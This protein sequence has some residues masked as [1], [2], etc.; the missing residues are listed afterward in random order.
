[1]SV[2]GV[3]VV[4]W[5][6]GAMLLCFTSSNQCITSNVSIATRS[7]QTSPPP[8]PSVCGGRGRRHVAA[9]RHAPV[10]PT[11]IRR[12]AALRRR[13]LR[14]RHRHRPQHIQ[15]AQA[16]GAGWVVDARCMS[17]YQCIIS[18]Y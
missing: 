17:H 4:V 9:G 7:I 2:V 1:M 11:D 5:L 8:T 13:H 10:L 3:G 14:H 18:N 12:V 16:R 15:N 6:L